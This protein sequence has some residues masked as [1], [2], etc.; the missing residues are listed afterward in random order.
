MGRAV[1]REEAESGE[2]RGGGGGGARLKI[3]ELSKLSGVG[4]EALRF[5]ERTGLLGRPRRTAAGYRLYDRETVERLDF[6]KRAQVLGFTLEEIR[7]VIADKE[8]GQSPCAEVRE[9]VRRRLGELDERMREMR[10]YRSELAAALAE[11]DEAGDAEGHVCGLIEGAHIEH[12]PEP[13][14]APVRRK[15]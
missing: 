8:A 7:R 12:R 14:K 1:R 10:R 15:R 13:A 4:V 5:Y 2:R 6:I 3:G 9:I 11:W